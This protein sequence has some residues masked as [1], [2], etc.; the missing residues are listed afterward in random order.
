MKAAG[1]D[2]VA[3]NC[4]LGPGRNEVATTVLGIAL[5]GGLHAERLFF[6]EA[7]RVEAIAGDAQA[8]EIGADGIGA[9]YAQGQVVF[10]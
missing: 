6:A 7:D 1:R 5:F 2:V 3:R 4:R 9:T 10:G 8:D